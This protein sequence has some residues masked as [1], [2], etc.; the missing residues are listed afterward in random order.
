[1]SAK[2]DMLS[3]EWY[4]ANFD[5]E[6]ITERMYAKDLCFELNN[7]SIRNSFI[8]L[9]LLRKILPNVDVEK[10]EILSPLMVD[11]GYNVEIGNGSYFNHNIYLMDCAKIVFGKKCFIGPNC[12]FYTA[13]HP[14]EFEERNEGFEIA[15]PI[16]VGN[17]VWICGDVTV[18][19]GVEIGNNSVIGA[20]SLVTKNIPDGVLAFGNPC[21]IIR[22]INN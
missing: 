6:L 17:N 3:G 13:I 12:N 9:E 2:S 22:K 4:N 19:P 8:R 18:L 7:T 20:K 14:L 15:K 5:A 11:Y 10:I 16:T 21:K 1:M